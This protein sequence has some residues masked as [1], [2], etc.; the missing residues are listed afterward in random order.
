MLLAEPGER[1]AQIRMRDDR[2]ERLALEPDAGVEQLPRLPASPRPSRRP[3]PARSRESVSRGRSSRSASE[4]EG[5]LALGRVLGRGE[6]LAGA[7]E[8]LLPVGGALDLEPDAVVEV[9]LRLAEPLLE[10]VRCVG[11][12]PAPRGSTTTRISKPCAVRALHPAQR[13]LLACRVG[14]EAEVEALRQPRELAQMLLGERRAHRRDDRLEP[15]LPER[16]HVGVALDDDRPVL[17]RDRGPGEVEAVEHAALLEQLA[18]GRVDVL[19]LAA[20]RRRGASA[21]GSRSPCRARRRAGTSAAAG[22]SRCHAGSSARPP[23]AR[24]P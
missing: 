7:D 6:D 10:P 3:A 18:L 22:S 17:L 5:L 8:R 21:P 11:R 14:V 13:R 15:R 4:A 2:G 24:R 1:V 9:A 16:D 19:S 23:A 12:D 20:G